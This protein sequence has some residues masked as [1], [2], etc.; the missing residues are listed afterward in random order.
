MNT[1]VKKIIIAD[2][3]LYNFN[4]LRATLT[5]HLFPITQKNAMAIPINKDANKLRKTISVL[6]GFIFR[7]GALGGSITLKA[8]F[9]FTSAIIDVSIC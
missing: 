9:S 7:S 2:T 5:F 3:F 8:K 6:F 4:L 1:A